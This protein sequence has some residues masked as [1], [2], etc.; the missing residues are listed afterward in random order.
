MATQ[1]STAKV[2]APE[3][4]R[5]QHESVKK[6]FSEMATAR[7][8]DRSD[9]FDCLRKT[10]AVHETAEEMVVYPEVRAMNKAAEHA[11][12]A[13]LKEESDAKDVLSQLEKLG[14]DDP[15][16]DKL[17]DSFRQSVLQHASAEEAQIFPFLEEHVAGGKLIEMAELIEVAESMAPTHPH[18]HGPESGLGNLMVGPF[19]AMVDK[20]RDKFAEHQKKK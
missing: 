11:V 9:L 1:R 16:F 15:K 20:V 12:E 10:L 19:V 17:F 6:M 3:L 18:P 13:R 14:T 4:L 5:A 2:T 7:G 8:Q